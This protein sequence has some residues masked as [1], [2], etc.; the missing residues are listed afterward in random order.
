MGKANEQGQLS[1]K[2]NLNQKVVK[3]TRI[4]LDTNDQTKSELKQINGVSKFVNP[5][6]AKV[7][8][9]Q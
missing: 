8:T 5:S 9:N 4:M 3:K 6:G 2:Q 7:G 1:N